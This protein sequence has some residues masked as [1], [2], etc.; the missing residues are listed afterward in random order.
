MEHTWLCLLIW[1]TT[2]ITSGLFEVPPKATLDVALNPVHPGETDAPTSSSISES[3][4]LTVE[5]L[6]IATLTVDLNPVYPGE[7]VTL[8]CSVESDINWIYK[9][10]KDSND[11]SVIQSNRHNIT[12]PTLTISSV[13]ESDQGLYWCHGERGD[14]PTS[15]SISDPVR[16][17]VKALPTATLTV[18]PNPVYAGEEVT[19]KCSAG[20][21]SDWTEYE[22]YRGINE[23]TV[24][25]LDYRT[26][27]TLTISSDT[28]GNYG[29]YKCRGIRGS[30]P[31]Y[32]SFSNIVRINVNALPTVTLKS[33]NPN[34][35]FTREKVTLT[36]SAG[37]V[38]WTEYVWY[39]D[40]T[41]NINI[42]SQYKGP[43][44]TIIST[45]LSDKGSYRCRGK[46]YS[47]PKYSSLSNEV[48]I[49]VNALP[50]VTLTVNANPVYAGEKVT[51]TCSAEFY[52]DWIEYE[53]Y[54]WNTY[55]INILSQYKGATLTIISTSLSDKGSYRCR[56]KQYLR[57]NYSSFSNEVT[58]TVNAL[59]TA[60]LT[61]NPN[62][63]Y[64][65]EKVTLTCSAGSGS[66][67]E[68]EWYKD[69]TDNRNI[70]SQYKGPTLTISS[71]SV[72]DKGSYRCRGKQYLR[73]KY[74]SFSNEVTINVNG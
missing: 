14:R 5:A 10:N 70:L 17:T 42:L 20:S 52:R 64:A 53:W 46:Q 56:G 47:R 30:R 8:T 68:Y 32:S 23:D 40:N 27:D 51:L 33:L 13:E 58:I 9:W 24:V 31:E 72:S 59:P 39:K 6:P 29:Y 73:P 74:S 57:P 25:N 34:P 45:S 28:V 16:L 41:D 54:K 71:T 49:N 3:V 48:I 62:P 11:T 2:L 69:N 35:V 66:W 19:L 22:W 65:G 18:N 36:C 67:T 37:S 26:G 63:V 43:T 44:L 21:Y 7:T 60:T 61:V 15:S 4:K 12:G 55:N 38:S 1:Q 50:T